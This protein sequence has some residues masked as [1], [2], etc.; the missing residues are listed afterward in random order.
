MPGT[1]IYEVYQHSRVLVDFKVQYN[2]GRRYV[3]FFDVYNLT[4][5][6]GANDYAHLLGREV[7]SYASG[8]G[9]SFKLG[10]TVRY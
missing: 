10:T 7:P 2:L 9:T 5:D 3:V 4:K 6:F 1:G 8:A